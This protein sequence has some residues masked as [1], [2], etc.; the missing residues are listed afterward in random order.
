MNHRR[1]LKRTWMLPILVV[2]LIASHG[3]VFYH[4]S[5]RMSLA[6][7]MA[8]IGLVLLKLF[9]LFGSIYALF[10]RR[11]HGSVGTLPERDCER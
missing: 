11:S 10:R 8:L 7:L 9:G 3:I 1:I 5:S 4:F 2:A 6:V